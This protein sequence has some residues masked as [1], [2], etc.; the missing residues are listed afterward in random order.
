MPSL[1]FPPA[2]ALS[3]CTGPGSQL[4]SPP[5][6]RMSSSRCLSRCSVPMAFGCTLPFPKAAALMVYI[7]LSGVCYALRVG[8]RHQLTV[9]EAICRKLVRPRNMSR[10][11]FAMAFFGWLCFLS[12]YPAL[13]MV[14]VLCGFS[15]FYYYYPNANG[16]GLIFAPVSGPAREVKGQAS[17]LDWHKFHIN[18]GSEGSLTLN[19]PHINS[20]A[21]GLKSWPWRQHPWLVRLLLWR[22]I[23]TWLKSAL[24]R[25]IWRAPA[26]L[27]E[28]LR[29]PPQPPRAVALDK[30]SATL[31]LLDEVVILVDN[32]KAEAELERF[33]GQAAESLKAGGR[34]RVAMDA[35]WGEGAQPLSLLQLAVTADFLPSPLV[36]VVDM[37]ATPSGSSVNLCRR[38]LIQDCVAQSPGSKHEILT[39]SPRNDRM[40]L[41]DAGVLPEESRSMSMEELGWIDLQLWNLDLGN[42]PGLAKIVRKRLGVQLDKRMQTSD[43]CQRPLSQQ[44]LQ[45][46]ALDAACLLRLHSCGFVPAQE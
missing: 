19:L 40:R 6:W 45:Y 32:E 1:H 37:Q 34:L 27:S 14:G 11:S 21:R 24:R 25:P 13:E 42:R 22:S 10:R 43:W 46:A 3:P 12:V 17:R 36:F 8:R 18:V 5:R 7:A 33:V 30:S 39:F 16:A 28:P 20:P 2:S 41:M 44:Q 23:A 4:C 26:E 29:P 31:T 35:E 38:L 9:R 15:A